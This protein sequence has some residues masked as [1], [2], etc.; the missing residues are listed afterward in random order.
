MLSLNGARLEFYDLLESFDIDNVS[1]RFFDREHYSYGK[2]P[3]NVFSLS[4]DDKSFTYISTGDY[5][6]VS[7][8]AKALLYHSENL[9]VG[10]GGN[11]KYYRFDMRLPDI[12]CINYAEK[13]RLTDGAS[14]YYNSLGAEFNYIE[15]PVRVDK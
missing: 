1:L 11:T 12:K 3:M 15:K 2:Y 14:T 10:T 7:V 5:D 6:L 13:D 4:I 8:E 9:F